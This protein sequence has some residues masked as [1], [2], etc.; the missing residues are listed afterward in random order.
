MLKVSSHTRNVNGY[1]SLPE[2][3]GVRRVWMQSGVPSAARP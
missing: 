3:E 2:N 1:I